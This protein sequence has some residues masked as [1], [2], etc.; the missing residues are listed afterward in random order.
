MLNEE[1][2]K[3]QLFT[4][5]KKDTFFKISKKL[6]IKSMEKDTPSKY[7]SEKNASVAELQH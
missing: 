7:Q 3:I 1:K 6:E 5:H 4:T 2:N